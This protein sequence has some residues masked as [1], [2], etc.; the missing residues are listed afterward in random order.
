MGARS[1]SVSTF[2]PSRSFF[3][4]LRSLEGLAFSL[5]SSSTAAA[6][7]WSAGRTD[8]PAAARRRLAPPRRRRFRSARQYPSQSPNHVVADILLWFADSTAVPEKTYNRKPPSPAPSVPANPD[9]SARQFSVADQHTEPSISN[10]TLNVSI[11]FETLYSNFQQIQFVLGPPLLRRASAVRP[12][13]RADQA[14]PAVGDAVPP[15]RMS[16]EWLC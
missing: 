12:R 10:R 11:L 3:S 9:H 7:F 1:S 4:S 6:P 5:A 8:W 15:H 2:S 14:Q 16:S 13:S